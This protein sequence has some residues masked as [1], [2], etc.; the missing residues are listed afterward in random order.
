MLD[1]SKMHISEVG[2]YDALA[3]SFITVNM[4]NNWYV[5]FLRLLYAIHDDSMLSYTDISAT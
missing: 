2:F 4:R 1:G 5:K 3:T